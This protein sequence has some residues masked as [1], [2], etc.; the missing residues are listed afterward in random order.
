MARRF[1]NMFLDESNNL[2]YYVVEYVDIDGETK[3]DYFETDLLAK[4]FYLELMSEK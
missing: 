3:K 2:G 1:I 4:E